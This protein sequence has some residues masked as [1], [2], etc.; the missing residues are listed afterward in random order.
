MYFLTKS[1]NVI[2]RWF[3]YDPILGEYTAVAQT[4][5]ATDD[6]EYFDKGKAE[7][8]DETD[9]E[10]SDTNLT[11][12]FNA[13]QARGPNGKSFIQTVHHIVEENGKTIREN[14]M[15]KQHDVPVGAL[16]EL[17]DKENYDEEDKRDV[18]CRLVVVNHSRDCDGTPLYDLALPSEMY[19]IGDDREERKRDL[20][21]M[22][23]RFHAK[24]HF[25]YGRSC[26]RPVIKKQVWL[27]IETGEFS[28]SWIPD[29]DRLSKTS[30]LLE[31]VEEVNHK[32]YN[33]CKVWKL[34]EFECLSDGEFEFNKMMR[35]R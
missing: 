2:Y 29:E 11:I 14:N 31:D 30:R 12:V 18:G 15:E 1:T 35:L 3:S 10:L 27:N 6:G 34:I 26:F 21:V 13:Q 4:H 9:I 22:Q 19:T 23:D 16:V 32:A 24:I 8:V 25:H 5:W 7:R 33:D 28:N 20:T 17:V